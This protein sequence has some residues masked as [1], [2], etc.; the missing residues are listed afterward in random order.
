MLGVGDPGAL[1]CVHVLGDRGIGDGLGRRLKAALAAKA[2]A[3]AA[4]TVQLP[5]HWVVGCDAPSL[6]VERV[7]IINVVIVSVPRT[8]CRSWSAMRDEAQG[9]IMHPNLSS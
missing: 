7:I 1:L 6:G 8:R 5:P 2:A 3:V 9:P 4:E